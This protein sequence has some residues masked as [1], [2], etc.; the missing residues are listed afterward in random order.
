MVYQNLA[1]ILSAF[2]CRL[3]VNDMY[4]LIR[5]VDNAWYQQANGN[6]NSQLDAQKSQD[7][8]IQSILGRMLQ[9]DR[10]NLVK[11]IESLT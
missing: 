1:P 5:S 8:L 2:V 4:Q 3:T 10:D 6:A 7:Q 9:H 11:I